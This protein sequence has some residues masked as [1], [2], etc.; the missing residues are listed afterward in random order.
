M[1]SLLRA[2]VDAPDDD[3]PRLVWA[4]R[5]G[6]DRGELV[7]L[8]CMLARR[9]GTRPERV[10]MAARVRELL[11]RFQQ[12]NEILVRGFVESAH[13]ELE[14]IG[15]ELFDRLP[16][17]RALS[18]ADFTISI[19]PASYG[20]MTLEQSWGESAAHLASAFAR[21]PPGRI[22]K[23]EGTPEVAERGDYAYPD[24]EHPF[25][26]AFIAVVAA[27]PGLAGLTELTVLAGDI[28]TAALPDLATLSLDSLR[29]G[30][31]LDGAG[32]VALLRAVPTLRRLC[33]FNGRPKINGSELAVLL[34][35]PEIARLT[36]LDL[37]ANEIGETE[38]LRLATAPFERLE[39]LGLG[40]G[41]PTAHG[42][43]ALTASPHLASLVDLDLFELNPASGVSPAPFCRAPFALQKLRICGVD[44]PIAQVL[45]RAPALER[46]DIDQRSPHLARLRETIPFVNDPHG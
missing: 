38:L 36:E 4:D 20:E 8:Q 46:L 37:W 7:V 35:A 14:Q 32:C 6:G 13:V 26:D 28:T 25:G 24:D 33:P 15:P 44:E 3:A 22:R 2:I 39:R 30:T 34:A 10:R 16:L 18:L 41:T 11:A 5:E 27:A 1:D 12:P 42:L 21:L 17:L 40:M 43:D 31:R 45:E 23:L 9:A 29:A 19:R